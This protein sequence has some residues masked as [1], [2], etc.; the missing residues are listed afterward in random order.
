[1]PATHT[2]RTHIVLARDRKVHPRR[3]IPPSGSRRVAAP[4][5]RMAL[6]GEIDRRH[7]RSRRC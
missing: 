6:A 1:M 7:A 5:P 3:T 4:K 2:N